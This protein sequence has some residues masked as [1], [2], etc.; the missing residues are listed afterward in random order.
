[1]TRFAPLWEGLTKQWLGAGHNQE[2]SQDHAAATL[3]LELF[4]ERAVTGP[5]SLGIGSS[6]VP[7]TSLGVA[8]TQP[9]LGETH[10]REAEQVKAAVPQKW[11]AREGSSF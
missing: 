2:R 9:L 10:H 3:S 6:T 7:Q 4:L 5:Q 1:M 8:S 11:G